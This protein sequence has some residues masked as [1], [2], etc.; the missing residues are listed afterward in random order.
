MVKMA[1]EMDKHEDFPVK[2]FFEHVISS[3]NFLLTANATYV[4]F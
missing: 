4:R 3:Q 1:A 2:S